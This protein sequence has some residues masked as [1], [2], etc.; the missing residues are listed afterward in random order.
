MHVRDHPAVFMIAT[1]EVLLALLVGAARVLW[2]VKMVMLMP[3]L[4]NMVLTQRETV[5]LEAR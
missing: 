2:G 1:T 5:D 4:V 3:A